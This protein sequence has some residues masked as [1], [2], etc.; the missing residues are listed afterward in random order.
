MSARW[1]L[2][3]VRGLEPLARAASEVNSR[4]D[5]L[6]GTSS[7]HFVELIKKGAMC[8]QCQTGRV[9]NIQLASFKTYSCP[10]KAL[11]LWRRSVGTAFY[12]GRKSSG[13]DRLWPRYPKPIAA[14]LRVLPQTL[15]P[16]P[17]FC[18][19]CVLR[20]RV[21]S[22]LTSPHRG[23]QPQPSRV[24]PPQGV[25]FSQNQ[26]SRP[27]PLE[28]QAEPSAQRCRHLGKRNH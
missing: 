17:P 2:S 23:T 8:C 9:L 3:C 26:D 20:L 21:H 24:C 7:A 1:S 10:E 18:R 27:S 6:T 28:C 5:S 12:W 22:A 25:L 15:P 19:K 14:T 13:H 16:A 11:F 4:L